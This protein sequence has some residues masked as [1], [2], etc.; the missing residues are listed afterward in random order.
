MTRFQPISN[1]NDAY[2]RLTSYFDSPGPLSFN[3][4][5]SASL[6]QEFP[7]IYS[8][9]H[10][11]P[12]T[13]FTIVD[14]FVE[15]ASDKLDFIKTTKHQWDTYIKFPNTVL[16]RKREDGTYFYLDRKIEE[17]QSTIINQTKA[18]ADEWFVGTCVPL[19]HRAREA[20]TIFV[21]GD[22]GSGK[23]TLFQI[24]P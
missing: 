19:L 4:D 22:P 17:T 24:P 5:F 18:A 20:A 3:K 14:E 13:T 7:A 8:P 16:S 11:K 1:F 12:E 15:R 6:S 10:P 21:T 9:S 23:S 2:D